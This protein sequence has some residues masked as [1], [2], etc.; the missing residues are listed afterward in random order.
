MI[1]TDYMNEAR[2]LVA[3]LNRGQ[4]ADRCW[5]L[6][7]ARA[8]GDSE[9]LRLRLGNGLTLVFWED[10][11]VPVFSFQTWFRVGSRH[12][13]PGRT[14]IAHLFEHLM[15]KATTTYA[16]GQFDALMEAR[17]A[18]TNAATWVDWTYYREKLPAGSLTLAC[19][20]ESD[21]MVNLDLTPQQLESEREVVK[22][23]RLMRV[24]NDPEGTLYEA[25]YALAYQHHSYRWPTIGTMADI[26][27]I[28]LDDCVAFYRSYYAP[29]NA[30]I[31]IVGDVGL[32][33]VLSEVQRC[34]GALSRQ[35]I[36]SETVNREPPQQAPRRQTLTLELSTPRILAA[37]HAVAADS[38]DHVALEVLCEIIAGGESSYL[39]RR[40]V[41]ELEIATDATAWTAAWKHPGLFEFQIVLRS[42]Q[43][44]EAA[45]RAFAQV[46]DDFIANG[47]QQRDLTKAVNAIEAGFLRGAGDT[48]NRARGLGHA[49]ATL[50]Y[51]WYFDHRDAFK[52][53]T[54]ADVN[55]VATTLL[56]PSNR[57]TVV[58][59][60]LTAAPAPA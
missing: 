45:E 48:G 52:T 13:T 35:P 60:P 42:G 17:G 53:V 8:M 4:G 54:A 27:A 49:E 34:Y 32:R 56:R 26:E 11:R 47:V 19:E 33:D 31:V 28:T 51:H 22:N 40:L 9:I 41:T 29:N 10:H 2:A 12:E 39:Y 36:A 1:S 50:D 37:Y 5:S 57:S 21:R 59:L 55:R 15:F 6:V 14:G 23:E 44:V 43:D 25:L 20:L 30:I 18:Q 24:D 3:Q 38:P 7:D 16:E 46:I 58:G